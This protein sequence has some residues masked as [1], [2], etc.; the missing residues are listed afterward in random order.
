MAF[1]D[2]F[3]Q[4]MG[5]RDRDGGSMVLAEGSGTGR[6]ELSGARTIAYEVLYETQPIVAAVVNKLVRQISTLPLEVYRRSVDGARERVADHPLERVL[7]LPAPG[8]GAHSLGQWISLPA[9]VFGNALLV[10]VRGADGLSVGLLL[11]DWRYTNAY[12]PPGEPIRLWSTLQ[13]GTELFI[14]PGEAVHFGW[15]G[16]RGWLG[17]SP[18]SQLDSTLRIEDAARRFQSANFDNGVRP[19]GAV[20]LQKDIDPQSEQGKRIVAMMKKLHEGVDN[21]GRLV[22]LG[23]GADFKAFAQTVVEAALIEQRKLSREEIEM[24]YDVPPP[25]VGDLEHGTY[26]NVSELH[27]QLYKTTLRPWL[28]MIAA[29]INAQLIAPEPDWQGLYVRYDLSDVLRGDPADEYTAVA[30][31]V[32]DGIIDIN[33]AREMLGKNPRPEPEAAKLLVQANNVAPLESTS[34]SQGEL[35]PTK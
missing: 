26:S 10:K 4:M 28:S 12:A 19:S 8:A 34:S 13:T 17:V 30:E 25:V 6:I 31:L 2:R 14:D 29:T 21:A 15:Q 1:L 7:G 24:V 5:R 20:V 18:L 11:I 16:S 35:T 23:G 9:L 27:K 32:R 22:L 3:R 33:E